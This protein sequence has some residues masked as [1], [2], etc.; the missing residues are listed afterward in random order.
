MTVRFT[1]V[2]DIAATPAAVFALSLDVDAHLD[3]MAASGE[4]AV[5]G[6]TG[7]ALRLGD[8]VTW[9][10][11]HFGVPF[12]MTSRITALDAPQRFVDEQVRGPFRSFRHEH[13]FEAT[14]AGT[15]MVDEVRFDAPLGP[16]G[17][18][19][20]GAVLG[21]YLERLIEQRNAHLREVLEH[22]VE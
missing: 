20:E 5:G 12:T 14:A 17:R 18:L 15:H 13:R 8:E 22:V 10:A 21:R 19:V 7:G 3:S 4:R 9:R 16:L 6:V 11:R 1:V 2:T